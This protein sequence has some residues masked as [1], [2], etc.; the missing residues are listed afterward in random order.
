MALINCPECGKEISD[1][2][3]VCINCG[4]PISRE[5]NKQFDNVNYLV[6]YHIEHLYSSPDCLKRKKWNLCKGFGFF[7]W[8]NNNLENGY[9]N[10]IELD[11]YD[12]NR[13]LLYQKVKT[14]ITKCSERGE[15]YANFHI[16]D[17]KDMFSLVNTKY[18]VESGCDLPDDL[19]LNG[20][21]SLFNNNQKNNQTQ[22]GN[23][24]KCPT[25]GSDSIVRISLTAKAVNTFAFGI[26]GTKRNKQF[27]CNN[28]KY[29]W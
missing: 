16:D 29:E 5:D 25:C 2:A 8:L 10:Y 17:D 3:K 26:F 13:K 6:I 27:R 22:N 11:Y 23:R 21:D 7:G 15:N 9:N 14:K 24:I 20:I 19:W 4:Y 1:K 28:C 12:C 18:I